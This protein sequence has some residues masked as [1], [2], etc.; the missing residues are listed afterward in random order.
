MRYRVRGEIEGSFWDSVREGIAKEAFREGEISAED[1]AMGWVSVED[2]TDAQFRGASYLRG[3]YVALA[4]RI[5]TLRV[6]PRIVELQLKKESRRLL[7]ESGQARLSSSQHRELKERIRE[8]LKRQI[9][10]S[11]QV[12]DLV[13]DTALAIAYF[14][15]HSPKARDRVE[16]LFKKSFGLTLVPLIPY[17]RAEELV[18]EKNQRQ[19]L[20]Q[21]RPASLA[22]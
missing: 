12:F 7:E 11:V 1:A 20:E 4:L 14:G 15:S 18:G 22:F 9:L 2:F 8:T 10:P 3:N 19:I 21:L 5:D 6:P 13:W 17:L 16:T